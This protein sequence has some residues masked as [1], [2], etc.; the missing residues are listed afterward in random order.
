MTQ[1]PLSMLLNVD[2]KGILCT[3]LKRTPQF[4]LI[5][6]LQ[7]RHWVRKEKEEKEN[8]KVG[9]SSGSCVICP[10]GTLLTGGI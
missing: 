4:A 10:L 3:A 5:N 8:K 7:I 9:S 6:N 2:A 1:R